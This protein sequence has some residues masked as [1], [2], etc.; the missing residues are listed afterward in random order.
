M[1]V[2]KT[3]IRILNLVYVGAAAFAVF[4][5]ATDPFLDLKVSLK[6]PTEL[7]SNILFT[8]PEEGQPVDPHQK[9]NLLDKLERA[10]VGT[11]FENVSL[12]L[13]VNVPAKTIFDFQKA[14]GFATNV[15]DSLNGF[16]DDLAPALT[17]GFI[18]LVDLHT[19]RLAVETLGDLVD[20]NIYENIA[21]FC[22][23]DDEGVLNGQTKE[24]YAEA[25]ARQRVTNLGTE[26]AQL[27]I[28]TMKLPESEKSSA[29]KLE[30]VKN[31]VKSS[32]VKV[33]KA[34]TTPTVIRGYAAFD[35]VT[36]DGLEA[37]VNK[38]DLDKYFHGIATLGEMPTAGSKDPGWLDQGK[39][40]VSDQEKIYDYE[41]NGN[42]YLTLT[43]VSAT[44]QEYEKVVEK[45]TYW[46]NA[47]DAMQQL[48]NGIGDQLDSYFKIGDK[49]EFYSYVVPT[50]AGMIGPSAMKITGSNLLVK[51]YYQN[52][53]WN[54]D[55]LKAAITINE[56]DYEVSRGF[57]KIIPSVATP[58][59][60]TGDSITVVIQYISATDEDLKS[61]PVTI[62]G[63]SYTNSANPNTAVTET[64]ID[65]RGTF[66]E[67]VGVYLKSFVAAFG[68]SIT[69]MIPVD[70]LTLGGLM[71]YVLLGVLAF[72]ALPW[73]ILVLVSL[74]RTLRPK[75]CWTKVW[76]VFLL[77]FLQLVLG[78][79]ITKGVTIAMGIPQ[80]TELLG[81]VTGSIPYIGPMI[82]TAEILIKFSTYWPSLIYVAMI[83]F[84]IIYAIFAHGPKKEFKQWKRD[85][86]AAKAEK[87]A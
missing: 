63:L 81:N 74:I 37:T 42:T 29:S 23:E 67:A 80:V 32:I 54:F 15:M 47:N 7:V 5:L 25:I 13:N 31:K 11:T 9:S 39:V 85:R 52:E 73:A 51:Q 24:Q 60:M 83:P 71:G 86:K 82:P 4:K 19:Y 61:A 78:V 12:D 2:R 8:P 48:T 44:Q 43:S 56:K 27:T 14:D 18:D 26:I 36:L 87:T 62:S 6:D 75:K 40:F 41:W 65:Y 79:V 77:G 66:E 46:A 64:P 45:T 38:D 59:E 22:T 72:F 50:L 16:V 53:A 69:G 20:Q 76:Y 49:Y 1:S 30:T 70:M 10:D 68:D 35:D 58:A 57:Y 34:M 55:G 33:L 21:K 17:P 28:D 84:T 3:I